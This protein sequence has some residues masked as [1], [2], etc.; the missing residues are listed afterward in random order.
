M[1]D[2][3]AWFGMPNDRPVA[4]ALVT[5]TQLDMLGGSLKVV[6]KIEDNAEGFADLLRALDEA[7]RYRGN[8]GWRADD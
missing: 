7:E 4:L 6:F 5:Q 8:L 2:T 3:A 1:S